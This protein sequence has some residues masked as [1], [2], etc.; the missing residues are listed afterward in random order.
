M[1]MLHAYDSTDC[2]PQVYYQITSSRASGGP[3]WPT[4]V[5][6]YICWPA[7]VARQLRNAAPNDGRS[8]NNLCTAAKSAR[9]VTLPATE[10]GDTEGLQK[11]CAETDT[12]HGCPV[13]VD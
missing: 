3:T 10:K 7:A 8:S 13:G 5:A 4:P 6:G 9:F 1:I 11:G 2:M 12:G